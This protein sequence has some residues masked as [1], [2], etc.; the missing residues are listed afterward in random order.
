MNTRAKGNTYTERAL[1]P[2]CLTTISFESALVRPAA[3][4]YRGTRKQRWREP[5]Q[6]IFHA[7]RELSH[8]CEELMRSRRANDGPARPVWDDKKCNWVEPEGK[9]GANDPVG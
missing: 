3:L 8:P 5:L 4:V 7:L 2:R 6:M 1:A 9:P